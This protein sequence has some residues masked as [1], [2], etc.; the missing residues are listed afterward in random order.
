LIE[1]ELLVPAEPELCKLV[2]RCWKVDAATGH[3]VID[4]PPELAPPGP[5]DFAVC[6]R[7]VL[8]PPAEALL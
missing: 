4:I 6:G 5:Y 3:Q 7:L 2:D 8:A 1:R